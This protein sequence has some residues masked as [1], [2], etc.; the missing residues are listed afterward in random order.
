MDHSIRALAEQVKALT[1]A[2]A[3]NTAA[4]ANG[5]AQ[6]QQQQQQQQRPAGNTTPQYY[7]N[8]HR[9]SPAPP[10]L[11]AHMRPHLP[12]ADRGP[13]PSLVAP[14]HSNASSSNLLDS[15]NPPSYITQMNNAAMLRE[16]N[17]NSNPQVMPALAQSQPSLPPLGQP[18]S[19]D[20]NWDTIFVNVLS[21]KDGFQA[22]RDVLSHCPP[23]KVLPIG[24]G[25]VPLISP[26]LIL[27]LIHQLSSQATTGEGSED[28][29][30]TLWWLQRA[31]QALQANVCPPP[32]SPS[33]V[34]TDESV[35][36][37]GSRYPRLPAQDDHEH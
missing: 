28:A 20:E 33:I 18:V 9:A 21:G 7:A 24:P 3:A 27:G 10:P 26:L 31:S 13:P 23:D 2:S 30:T 8:A 1:A 19:Q 37:A 12:T 29:A 11:P 32:S 36:H 35:I 4:L 34:F 25:A 14:W 6:Q 17:N 5:V 15:P 22:L 16:T